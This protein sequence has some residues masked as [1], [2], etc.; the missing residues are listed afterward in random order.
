MKKK[1]YLPYNRG[2]RGAPLNHAVKSPDTVISKA[3][4]NLA[5]KDTCADW[6]WK[7]LP[8]NSLRQPIPTTRRA[9]PKAIPNAIVRPK[10]EQMI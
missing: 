4:P 1:E 10:R 3:N 5:A 6:A 2:R 9:V 8:G 7:L